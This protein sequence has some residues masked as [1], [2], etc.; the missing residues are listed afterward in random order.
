M[1]LFGYFGAPGFLHFL[2]LHGGVVVDPVEGILSDAG[3]GRAAEDGRVGVANVQKI[4]DPQLWREK[5]TL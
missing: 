3:T 2:V 1:L 4:A 5:I